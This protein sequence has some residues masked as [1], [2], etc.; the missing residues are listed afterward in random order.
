MNIT[1]IILGKEF[2][3]NVVEIPIS[4]IYRLDIENFAVFYV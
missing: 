4:K 2:V 3:K 1:P